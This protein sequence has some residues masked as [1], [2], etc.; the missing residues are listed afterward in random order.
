MMTT[1]NLPP[2]EQIPQAIAQQALAHSL[3]EPIKTYKTNN[4]LLSIALI[5]GS[6]AVAVVILAVMLF[7]NTIVQVGYVYF[8]TLAP[9]F[10]I[11]YAIRSLIK[12][13]VH[14]YVYTEGFLRARGKLYDIVRW[15][16]IESIWCKPGKHS[17]GPGLTITIRLD[18]GNVLKFDDTVGFVDVLFRRIQEHVDK[19]LLPRV[20]EDFQHKK[21]VTFGKIHVDSQG[22]NNEKELVPWDQVDKIDVTEDDLVVIIKHGRPLKWSPIKVQDTPNLSTLIG[23]VDTIV[24]EKKSQG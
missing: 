1:P 18:D 5:L 16:Q 21:D 17:Y 6:I 9:L 19:R 12:G 22:I 7:I 24:K 14:A 13:S 2:E 10:V 11:I 23:L 4:P 3:G 8:I 15:E 20:L